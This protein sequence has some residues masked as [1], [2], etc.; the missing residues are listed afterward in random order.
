MF[1]DL[2][3]SAVDRSER[4][5]ARPGLR[6]VVTTAWW[7]SASMRAMALRTHDVLRQARSA[8]PV[9]PCSAAT[10]RRSDR[11]LTAIGYHFQPDSANDA[12]AHPAGF[13]HADGR[14]PSVAGA[15]EPGAAIHTI[16]G[17]HS[18][19]RAAA[20]I[21][22]LAGRIALALLRLR[23]G[24]RHLHAGRSRR[25]CGSPADRRLRIARGRNLLHAVAEAKARSFGMNAIFSLPEATTHAVRVDHIFYGLLILSGSTMLLVFALVVDLRDPLSTRIERQTW[26]AAQDRQPRIRD[27]LDV[28]NAVPVRD[29]CSGGRPLPISRVS[30]RPPNALEIHVVAKQWMWKTQ[31][32]ERR[33]RDQRT[34][35]SGRQAGSAGDDFAGRHP[36]VLRSG[37]PHE[38]GRSARARHRDLVSGDQDWRISAALR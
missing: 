33:A 16:C 23:C 9:Y 2:R 8:A 10:A 19:K 22:G 21:G 3:T 20:R 1:A 7:S 4:A 34:A 26:T 15:V 25:C 5:C 6:P 27:R 29:S 13:R 17:W 32:A 37:V 18:S 31:H 36:F 28:G 38:T 35:R 14:R 11:S 24:P 12:I 30:R